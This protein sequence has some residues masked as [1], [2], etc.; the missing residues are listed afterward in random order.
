MPKTQVKCPRC[1]QP[2]V[3]NVEQLFDVSVD[4][5][6]KQRLLGASSNHVRCSS[7]G[8]SGSLSSPIVYHDNEKE[9]LLTFFPPELALPLNEQEKIFGPLINQVVNKLPA[10]KRKAYLF[11]PQSF[12]SFQSLIERILNADGI[13]PEMLKNQQGKV[14]LIEKL[15]STPSEEVRKTIIIQESALIDAEFFGLFSRLMESALASGQE[16]VARQMQSIQQTLLS[17]TDYGRQLQTQAT[18][19]QEAMNS[20]QAV[21]KK[22]TRDKL[23]DILVDAPN[24]NRLKALV[25][26]T[27]QGLDY[28]FFQILTGKIERSHSPQKEKL[29]ELRGKLLELTEEIDRH[30][31]VEQQKAKDLLGTLLSA[32]DLEKTISEHLEEINDTFVQVL[33]SAFKQ[34]TNNKDQLIVEK[35]QNIIS[36]IQ[37]ISTPPE[38]QLLQI[39]MEAETEKSLEL[40]LTQHDKAITEEFTQF[41]STIISQSES[42]KQSIPEK[43]KQEMLN[44]LRSIYRAVL[45]YTMNRNLK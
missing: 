17:E 5:A 9:L 6:S 25:S 29:S 15:F 34:A 1:Q 2:V 8:Y 19:L 21:G 40:L 18:E 26:L 35:L 3:V 16:P 45:K 28:E 39:L 42:E 31:Q 30:L 13:T 22:L 14:H 41:L 44:Q 32:Q 43:E 37:A 7:C 10:E 36:H 27:R 33:N 11:R 4:P 20:L 24:E 38:Y 12:L 23:L